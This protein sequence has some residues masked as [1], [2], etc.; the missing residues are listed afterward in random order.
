MKIGIIGGYG[1]ESIHAHPE[2]EFA[3]ADDGYD[4]QSAT[5][6]TS[7]GGR[8]F[9][10]MATLLREFDP[11][12]IYIGSAYARNGT[13]AA[14][15]LRA[16][17]SVVCEKPLASSPEDLLTLR[18]LTEST[19]L[20]I[21]AEY[22]MRWH[23]SVLKVREIV[24]SGALGRPIM[25]Q[26]QKTYKFGASRPDFYRQRA[27]FGGIIPWVASHAIDYCSWCTGLAYLSVSA[28]HGNRAFPDYPGMEDHAALFFQMAGQIPCLITA[29]FL[30]P[31][32]AATHGDDRLRITGEKAVV[33]MIDHDVTLIDAAGTHHWHCPT[34]ATCD[35]QR[36]RDLVSAAL[37][38][39]GLLS[40]A[41]SFTVT[42][43]TLAA[44]TAADTHAQ[45][46]RLAEIEI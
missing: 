26:G 36:A 30:R 20:H 10:D 16:G 7:R 44:R 27:T 35:I 3:W 46:G 1:H 21:V 4:H 13:L 25:V 19:G 15:A 18:T 8:H 32:G 11:T 2:A 22:T 38:G 33:E 29:D 12:I 40:M 37:G 14:A 17:K 5:R 34:T 23:P 9:A 42:A 39:P 45:T 28:S 6:A 31:Q 41:E 43:A 24:Q